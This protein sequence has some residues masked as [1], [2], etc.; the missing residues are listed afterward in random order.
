MQTKCKKSFNIIVQIKKR[1]CVD[2][3]VCMIGYIIVYMIDVLLI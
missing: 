1:G 2:W 3:M